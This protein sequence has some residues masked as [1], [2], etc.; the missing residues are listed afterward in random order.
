M[1]FSGCSLTQNSFALALF[2]NPLS[3]WRVELRIESNAAPHLSFTSRSLSH[4]LC[5]YPEL[6]PL[7]RNITNTIIYISCNYKGKRMVIY[8]PIQPTSIPFEG[9]W[10]PFLEALTKL[11]DKAL[12]SLFSEKHGKRDA[13]ASSFWKSF[14]KC[15]CRW[16]RL[17]TYT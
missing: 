3:S 13:L 2:T 9:T 14:A 7:C 12:G 17:Y 5:K 10:V 8:L 4:L 16:D 11:Q 1:M 15:H 6:K